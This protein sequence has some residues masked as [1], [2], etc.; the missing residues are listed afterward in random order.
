MSEGERVMT[1]GAAADEAAADR[2]I[3]RDYSAALAVAIVVGLALAFSA[4]AGASVLLGAVAVVQALLAFSWLAG[5]G[6]PG[7]KGALIIG[8][9]AAAGADVAV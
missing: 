8:A 4:R 7:R 1:D 6:M 9:F 2:G 3:E 5:T